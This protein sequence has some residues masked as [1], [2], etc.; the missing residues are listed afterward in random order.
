MSPAELTSRVTADTG[1]LVAA[2][3]LLAAW[4]GGAA[5][6]V[7][8]LAGGGLA[9]ANFRWLAGRVLA[10]G[11]VG[12]AAPA[13][14]WIPGFALRLAA[15]GVATAVLVATGWAHPVA[16]VAGLTT[17]PCAVVARGLAQAGA[18]S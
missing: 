3:A 14:G 11:E 15:M 18:R 13:G 7:G 6:A 12:G 16:L 10:L 8:V 17:L 2:L 9:L 4:V 5:A 1:Y